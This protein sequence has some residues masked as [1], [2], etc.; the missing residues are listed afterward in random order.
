MLD[1]TPP[2]ISTIA[3]RST[4]RARYTSDLVPA[5]TTL[6]GIARS[7]HAH[8]NVLSI[9]TSKA[10]A[11]PGVLDVLTPEDFSGVA[12]GHHIADEPILTDRVRYVGEGVAAVA[13]VDEAA[14]IAGIAALDIEYEVLP[15]AIRVDDALAL[16]RPIHDNFPDNVARRFAAEPGD[17]DAEVKRVT[18]W[19]EGT[20]ET[21]AVPHAYLEP[22]ACLVRVDGNELELVSGTHAPSMLADQYNKIAA[23]WG[24]TVEVT[25]PDMGGSFGAKWEHPTHL[26]CLSF[27]HRLQ[28]D[29][30]MVLPRRDDMIAGRTRIAMRIF[31]R[32]G[33]TA[34]GELVAKQTKVY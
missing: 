21:A 14:M 8:A 33:A 31:M 20:F 13:A 12:L 19:A 29:V 22:R 32:I 1:M 2:K 5:G 28:R 9:D 7:P 16:D 17:W 10:M 25:T 27:A 4:G 6:V 30:A 26:V 24:A 3:D 34:D 23:V 18:H 15:H 11:L